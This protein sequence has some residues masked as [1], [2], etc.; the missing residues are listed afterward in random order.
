MTTLTTD[1]LPA[2]LE[3]EPTSDDYLLGRATGV[4]DR[5]QRSAVTYDAR[6]NANWTARQMAFISNRLEIPYDDTINPLPDL[7]ETPPSSGYLSYDEDH[8]Y[9]ET[10]DFDHA[11]RGRRLYLPLDP[12]YG[13]D[14]PHLIGQL[15]L[16]RR[17]LPAWSNVLIYDDSNA[18]V[19]HIPVLGT[20]LHDEFGRE[21]LRYT[22]DTSS[23]VTIAESFSYDVRGRPQWHLAYRIP[24][25]SDPDQSLQD[26]QYLTFTFHNWDAANNLTY[27]FDNCP[28]GARPD[29][30]RLRS[31]AIMTHDSLYRLTSASMYYMSPSYTHPPDDYMD[32]RSDAA[33]ANGAD[34]MQPRPAPSAGGAPADRVNVLDYEW[35]WLGN[36]VA[37]DDDASSFY[38]RSLGTITNGRTEE[39][40]ARPSALY[41]ATNIDS[42]PGIEGGW[43]GAGWVEVDYGDS[44]NVES[45]TVH[46]ECTDSGSDTCTDN[47]S[48]SVEERADNF[49]D[50][51]TCGVEQHYSY[52][53]DELN[54]LVDARRYDRVAGDWVYQTRL[55]YRYDA[56][57]QRTV[58]E[59]FAHDGQNT[60]H[61]VAL[62]VYPG[63][64]E[65]R[66]LERGDG[67]YD[68]QT[69]GT[70]ESATETQYMVAGARIVWDAEPFTEGGVF[71]RNRRATVRTSDL[72]GTS[73]A[74]L[75]IESRELLEMATYYPSGARENL[76]TDEAAAP[77]EPVGF[78]G[79]EADEEIGAVYFG[80]RWL[81]PRLGRWA[82][83][84]PLHV[85]AS[86]GGEALNSYHYVGGNLLQARDPTGLG[87][88]RAAISRLA[89][90]TS[91]AHAVITAL[92]QHG[93]RSVLTDLDERYAGLLP[94]YSD[95]VGSAEYRERA[96]AA[97]TTG[98]RPEVEDG[99]TE[100][101]NHF[102]Q[103]VA[104][105]F[106]GVRHT[107]GSSGSIGSGPLAALP[108]RIVVGWEMQRARPGTV[109]GR[110]DR[111]GDSSSP[112]PT[113]RVVRG[114]SAPMDGFAL[115]VGYVHRVA[116]QGGD[117]DYGVIDA[118]LAPVYQAGQ[119]PNE[120]RFGA[121]RAD[122]R[123][124]TVGVALGQMMRDIEQEQEGRTFETNADAASWAER[125]LVRQNDGNPSVAPAS[126]TSPST[127]STSA[128]G[129]PAPTR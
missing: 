112:S 1:A 41:L 65:R 90:Q 26:L 95:E 34:P 22:G 55:R 70:G 71:D 83:P 8:T 45:F 98:Y 109:A 100:Q 99:Q 76:W 80:E 51:C 60:S 48:D 36:Q 79:K 73:T 12:D 3:D 11:G 110:A 23:T 67:T 61:R 104:I 4:S 42:S 18:F 106:Y 30:H 53:W 123:L 119:V 14:T 29:G 77:L 6:G 20:V 37:W 118:L 47:L 2:W 63:H 129:A 127:P 19:D 113:T 117:I 97:G 17:G 44:G 27:L 116:S 62:T 114:T 64:F 25:G 122:L 38:E 57:N 75:D 58:E 107:P 96:Q 94:R 126:G 124:T 82:T 86:G 102:L 10:S 49:R 120:P 78:T 91:A 33:A 69:S 87:P 32:W 108:L 50:G 35:D 88:I 15:A 74:V 68:F 92:G 59:S 93:A 81:I 21:T 101:S 105:G 125:Q 43:D 89:E 5:G 7:E 85:H 84:D 40:G 39:G 72:L 13:S 56:A 66:G 54:R 115:A 28:P 52:R 128:P 31:Y 9:I 46:G 103:A 111:G 24:S 121:S 16:D